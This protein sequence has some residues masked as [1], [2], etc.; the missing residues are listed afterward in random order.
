MFTFQF[1][2]GAIKSLLIPEATLYVSY[3][4]SNMVR[5]RERIKKKDLKQTK[6][7]QFQYG[8]IKSEDSF[9]GDVA[10]RI[11]QFQYGAIKSA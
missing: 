4:N 1:Q 5:L 3:F 7:F 9:I 8:A 2:Y 11:F 10:Q 6:I